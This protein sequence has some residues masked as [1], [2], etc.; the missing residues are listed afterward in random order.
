MQRLFWLDPQR[1]AKAF[2]GPLQA[3][4]LEIELVERAS[5]LLRRAPVEGGAVAVVLAEWSGAGAAL[6]QLNSARPDIAL[7]VASS[8]GVPSAL[9]AALEQGGG[10]VL[11]L[12]EG[13]HPKI[14]AQLGAAIKRS[15]RA[16]QELALLRRLRELNEA[17]VGKMRELEQAYVDLEAELDAERARLEAEERAG[18]FSVL[19]VDDEPT[20]C[21]MLRMLLE[22]RGYSVLTAAD[23]EEALEIF[24]GVSVQLMIVDKNL[25]G[26]DGIEV[27]RHVRYERPEVDVIII[28]G[29]ASKDS[30]I[31][32]LRLGASAYLEKPFEDLDRVAAEIEAVI[33]RQR[34]RN[35]KSS[36]LQEFKASNREFF[37]SYERVRTELETWLYLAGG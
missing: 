31:E 14:A 7:A 9:R 24:R 10:C 23:G 29:Y 30:A 15:A 16:Q 33:E 36:Y 26:I 22:P 4:G 17:F 8:S 6:Q 20:I 12:K 3:E 2:R 21:E 35:K 1:R 19:V 13:D 27:L 32:A 25:P 18:A 34:R 11:D 28:T 5:E 37:A